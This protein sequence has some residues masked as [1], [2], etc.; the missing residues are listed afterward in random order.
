MKTRLRT[1][2]YQECAK[3]CAKLSVA[4]HALLLGCICFFMAPVF[5]EDAEEN[6][7]ELTS[8]L[9][10]QGESAVTQ[11]EVPEGFE[12]VSA[13][14]VT[15]GGQ[16][17]SLYDV[18]KLGFKKPIVVEII[19]LP[20]FEPGKSYQ[21]R[22]V[23]FN[24]SP[25]QGADLEKFECVFSL[26]SGDQEKAELVQTNVSLQGG[27]GSDKSQC[28]TNIKVFANELQQAE[29][30]AEK[31]KPGPFRLPRAKP[32]QNVNLTINVDIVTKEAA[33]QAEGEVPPENP[34]DF[35]SGEGLGGS[36]ELGDIFE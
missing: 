22:A 15:N 35:D 16:V 9:S 26:G 33:Q 21:I 24:V 31:F 4:G 13:E 17:L 30:P 10:R 2:T 5:A 23:V 1:L 29:N 28:I 12:L 25:F 20:P 18:A 6:F 11:V 8:E 7:L 14:L 32:K 3:L 27:V 34:D 19:D 36:D